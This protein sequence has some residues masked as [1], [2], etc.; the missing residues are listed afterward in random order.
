MSDTRH[1]DQKKIDA[2]EAL[3][4]GSKDEV[5]HMPSPQVIFDLLSF[6][7]TI[8]VTDNGDGTFDV[9][10][11]YENVYMVGNGIF[12]VDNVDGTDNDDGTFT[13]ST[14]EA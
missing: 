4:Y 5:A 9:T 3:I 11:S 7:D 10:G 12:R 14:T 1:M 13:I 2:V 8:I 6:G